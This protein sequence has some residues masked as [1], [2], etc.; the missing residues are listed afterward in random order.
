MAQYNEYLTST[1][2]TGG[3][4]LSHQGIS[5]H[6]AEYVP[7]HV[8]WFIRWIKSHIIEIYHIAY[9]DL[10]LIGARPTQAPDLI[11]LTLSMLRKHKDIFAFSVIYWNWAGMHTVDLS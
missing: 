4:V 6:S 10:A 8:Q 9:D 2:D 11:C 3:L 7:I 5:S 1:V